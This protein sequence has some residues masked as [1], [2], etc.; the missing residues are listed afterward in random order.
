M[1]KRVE[2]F[3]SGGIVTAMMIIIIG[4]VLS[5]GGV[6]IQKNNEARIKQPMMEKKFDA[7][8]LNQT[9]QN[10]AMLEGQKTSHAQATATLVYM[11]EQTAI[12]KE[13]TVRTSH[14]EKDIIDC[15]RKSHVVR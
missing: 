15:K 14:N 10:K 5:W 12:I 13:L 9:L 7:Y 11:Y 2:S 1:S 8:I 6:N 3:F 4:G